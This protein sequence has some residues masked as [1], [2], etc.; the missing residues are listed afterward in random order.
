MFN[1]QFSMTVVSAVF[2]CRSI[3][4]NTYS[5]SFLRPEAVIIIRSYKVHMCPQTATPIITTIKNLRSPFYYLNYKLQS[6]Y[7]TN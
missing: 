4:H 7:S 1:M 3:I 6:S 5:D 2:F